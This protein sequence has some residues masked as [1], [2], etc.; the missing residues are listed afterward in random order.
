LEIEC[1]LQIERAAQRYVSRL[2]M[3]ATDTPAEKQPEPSETASQT[4]NK[5]VP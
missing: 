3:Q 1:P 4:V 2:V 5:Q